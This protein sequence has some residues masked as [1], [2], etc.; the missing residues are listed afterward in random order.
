[1]FNQRRVIMAKPFNGIPLDY[2]PK[3]KV[4]QE[5]KL[6]LKPCLHCGKEIGDGYYARYN[7]S[8]VC[9]KKCM[10]EHDKKPKYP[11]YEEVDFLRR[12][13]ETFDVDSGILES[14]E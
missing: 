9:S 10:L 2:S 3:K 6:D 13:G 14:G 4:E 8:G 5:V 7:D 1:M 11:N 12:Q